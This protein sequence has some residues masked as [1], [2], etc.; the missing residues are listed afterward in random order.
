MKAYTIDFQIG[1][2]LLGD[3]V[4]SLWNSCARFSATV[5]A[6]LGQTEELQ[7]FLL[8]LSEDLRE[9]RVSPEWPGTRLLEGTAG[10]YT[11]QCSK[12]ALGQILKRGSVL[13]MWQQPRMPE[14]LALYRADGSVVLESISHE[15]EAV[16]R[17][18]EEEYSTLPM[19]IRQ[20]LVEAPNG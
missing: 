12:D 6:G 7:Q 10:V 18:T 8:A 20:S 13:E 9:L 1:S 4:S 3:V 2:I 11:Y 16:V 14:D 5:R 17:L 19:S 15:G